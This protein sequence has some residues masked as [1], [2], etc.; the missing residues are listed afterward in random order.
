MINKLKNILNKNFDQQF[1]L[2][3]ETKLLNELAE[4]NL[5]ANI[6]HDSIRGNEALQK[7]SVNVGRWAGNYSFF[8]V[9]NRILK[10]FKP[11]NILELGLGESSKFISTF[12]DNSE[13]EAKHTIIE[14]DKKWI[15]F[16]TNNFQLSSK[17]KI[18]IC[19]LT[20]NQINNQIVT[21]YKDFDSNTNEEFSFIL[22][23]GPF[24]S[25]SYSRYDIVKY[26][27]DNKFDTDFAILFDD[28]HRIGEKETFNVIIAEL[29]RKNITFY[30]A[31]YAGIKA[32]SIISNQR[33][34]TS[35]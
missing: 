34:L 31:H 14:H 29:E 27:M 33:F 11:E 32:C 35:L 2:L 7:L 4:E 21:G 30:T 16:F 17:S 18:K 15:E 26:V 5:W 6:Y 1:K 23:D 19:E 10:D 13:Y 24:G 22:I 3:S 8:Y 25:D 20:E 28:T 12:I 9:L